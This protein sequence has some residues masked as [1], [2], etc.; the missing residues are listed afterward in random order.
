MT[1]SIKRCLSI[2][3]RGKTFWKTERQQDSYSKM[4]SLPKM[5][6][7]LEEEFTW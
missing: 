2:K 4:L 5:K 6:N 3:T 7:Q 1:A